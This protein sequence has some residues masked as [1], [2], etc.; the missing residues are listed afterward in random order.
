MKLILKLVALGCLSAC[1]YNDD[2]VT[3][4]TATELG[5]HG[6]SAMGTSTLGYSRDEL[7][8]AP[9]DPETGKIDPLY[10]NIEKT[11]SVF[12][13][14][15]V[16]TFSTGPAARI[17][18]GEDK[19]AVRKA[20]PE[21]NDVTVAADDS[22]NG[23]KRTRPLVFGTRSSI[24]LKVQANA[25]GAAL[26]LGY[27]RKE[28]ASIPL[29]SGNGRKVPSLFGSLQMNVETIDSDKNIKNDTDLKQVIATGAAAENA[30][31]QQGVRDAVGQKLTEAA[32]ASAQG[33][34]CAKGFIVDTNGECVQK[35]TVN[36]GTPA[37]N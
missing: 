6:D 27:K 13:P 30:A 21:D 12:N 25:T 29:H 35:L 8:I 36:E 11:R 32:S 14:K 2:T 3:F 37:I 28:Y 22:N 33:V 1:A 23:R 18:T 20:I 15:I 17:V 9:T 5:L 16:Q 31:G 4:V 24:G 10:A 7:V 19:A 34:T 26:D